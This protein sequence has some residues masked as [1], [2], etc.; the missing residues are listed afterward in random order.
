VNRG[1]PLKRRTALARKTALDRNAGALRRSEG[2]SRGNGPVAR[3]RPQTARKSPKVKASI[4]NAV[5]EHVYSREEGR[6][7]AC[8]REVGRGI[9]ERALHHCLPERT[10]P[11]FVKVAAN[12][13]LVCATCHV[14]HEFGARDDSRLRLADLPAETLSWL[15]GLPDGPIGVYL[16][17]TYR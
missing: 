17:R 9:F 7:V 8:R 5:R 10:W 13:V 2:L 12:V 1:E 11:E 16:E 3:S 6:C 4:P 15:R 14:E